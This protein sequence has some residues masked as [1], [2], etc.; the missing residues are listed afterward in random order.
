LPPG[1][2]LCHNREILTQT[3][4]TLDGNSAELGR[5]AGALTTFCREHALDEAIEFDLNLVLE[6]LFMNSVL[7][8]GCEGVPQAACVRLR[9]VPAGVEVAYL[10]R[11]FPF[12]PLDAPQPDLTAPLMERR[13]GGLGVHLL[14][15]I[16]RDVRYYRSPD[17]NELKMVRRMK[18]K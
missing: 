17:G 4:I 8:G 15:Q 5:L 1:P 12:N 13:A 14:R 3:E 18:P 2:R 9:I 10:D 7:H 11:G 6:E 16:M